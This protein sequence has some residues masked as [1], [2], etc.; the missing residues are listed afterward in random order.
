MGLPAVCGERQEVS[1]PL[2]LRRQ[3]IRYEE[4]GWRL[5]LNLLGCYVGSCISPV[6]DLWQFKS[7]LAYCSHMLTDVATRIQ[8]SDYR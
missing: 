6:M 4:I 7:A 2:S 3:P 8:I 5:R 1:F